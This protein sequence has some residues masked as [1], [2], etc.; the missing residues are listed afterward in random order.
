MARRRHLDVRRYDP[1]LS[2]SGSHLRQR[3]YTRAID[4][5]V[6]GDE[7]AHMTLSSK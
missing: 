5:V 2:E 6:V 1:D 7:D 3:G 4:A